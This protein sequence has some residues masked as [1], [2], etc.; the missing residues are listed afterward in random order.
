M[1]LKETLR[2]IVR[3]QRAEFESYDYGVDREKLGSIDVDVPYATIVSGIRRCG[4]STLMRQVSRSLQSFYYLRFEDIRLAGFEPSDFEKL[5]DIFLE[6]YGQSGVYLLDE[7]QNVEKWELFVRSRLDR[8]RR[9]VITGSNASLLSKELGTRLTGRHINVELFPFSFL[10]ALSFEKKKAS[11][12]QFSHYLSSGGFPEYLR[13]GRVEILNELLNDV[14]QRDIISRHNVRNSKALK[15]LAV[16][17]LTNIGKEFSYNG[18]KETFGLG[19]V[20]TAS[21][22]VS[23]FEDAYMIFTIPK[24]SYSLKEQAV[25]QKKVYCV[26]NGLSA[27]NSASFSSDNGAKLENMVFMQLRRAYDKIFYFKGNNECDFIVK[28][29]DRVKMAVQA[30][31]ELHEGNKKR[32]L[33]GLSEAMQKLG[34]SEGLILT[35][36]QE[37][38]LEVDGREVKVRPFWKWAGEAA[39]QR[40]HASKV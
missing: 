5:D 28:E 17:L 13:Y 2:A 40:A 15:E 20:T 4:K 14:I 9:F 38:N 36:D 32:E 33:N 10:E 8:Q 16:Y 19:S 37:D 22:F 21:A 27:I 26:D 30:T 7:V 12:S 11:A 29:R 31:Y 3:S 6:E 35:Y 25:N 24:F 34:L 39:L 1:I 23:Y 18:L